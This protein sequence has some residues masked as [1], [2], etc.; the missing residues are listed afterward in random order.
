MV[1]KVP[2]LRSESKPVVLLIKVII[3]SNNTFTLV[4]VESDAEN[5]KLAEN[6]KTL[7]YFIIRE[8]IQDICMEI[9]RLKRL[10]TIASK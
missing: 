6:G 3:C 7:S 2:I 5:S 9:T 1:T 4:D 8:A 10:I